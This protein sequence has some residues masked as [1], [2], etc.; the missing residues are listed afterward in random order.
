VDNSDKQPQKLSRAQAAGMK[1]TNP[2]AWDNSEA[3][4]A[5]IGMVLKKALE[6]IFC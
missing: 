4:D 1:G 5:R 2:Q 3:C 6:S